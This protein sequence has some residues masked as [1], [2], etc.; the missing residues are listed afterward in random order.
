[1]LQ[2]IRDNSQSFVSKIIIGLII[3]VFAL[4][5]AESIVGGFFG[6]DRAV[7]VNGD[8][9][10]ETELA[11][12]IQNL[13]ANIGASAA[14]FDDEFIR[15][16]ALNQLIEDRLLMQA[17]ADAGLQISDDSIDRQIL[18][19]PQFQLGGVFDRDL[20]VRTMASQ[21]FT[22]AM[23]RQA[24]AERM[25]IGQLANAYAGTGFVTRQELDRIAALS[26]QRRDFR[27]VSVTVG[28][29][30]L[31]EAISDQ[32]I[33]AYYDNNSSRFMR[34]EQVVIDY[35]VLDRDQIFDEMEIDQADV[36][37]AYER[38]RDATVSRVERRASHI[39]F[40]LSGRTEAEALELAT[41]LKARID[42]GESFADLAATYSDDVISGRDGGDIGYSDGS[43]FPDAVE[44]ALRVLEEG[45]VSDPVRSEFGVHLVLLSESDVADFPDF[46][47]M[48]D[49]IERDLL[50]SQV[51][52]IYFARLE[53]LANL[54]FET[55][56][57]EAIE[58]ELGLPIQ[59]SEAFGRSGG[60]NRITGSSRVA[61]AA[62]SS[63]VLEDRLN[64]DVIEVE[65]GLS[66]VIHLR[67]HRPAEL[68]PLD[69]V[70]SE[71]ATLLRVE[72]ER[73][74]TRE[75]GEEIL[76]TLRD[77]GDVDALLETHELEWRQVEDV[78]REDPFVNPEIREAAFAVRLDADAPSSLG[79]QLSNGAYV[80]VELQSVTDGSVDDLSADEREMLAEIM[81]EGQA[82]RAFD[83][84]LENR[85][86]D[87]RIR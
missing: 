35:V 36:M 32:E 15:E 9:I 61:D 84:L 20:A 79:R 45:E 2:S 74:R 71:I 77:G 34:E 53:T 59:Q 44:E 39:L 41:E 50:S 8:E 29:R 23:Y 81:T 11:N 1:M 76:A 13:M 55:F 86:A 70:R 25:L 68:R 22:P 46:D 80:V 57:L 69:E 73:V 17:A 12:S 31:D 47:E 6:A 28:A 42:A 78:S 26:A 5:G 18:Q 48:A 64:S 37:A 43:V 19:T 4:F 30:T 33:R 66:V 63:D 87:A 83:A 49:R 65:E 72:R 27:Y 60:S 51:E 38:E 56:D 3:G 52:Q 58:D 14:D 7:R 16:V 82:R 67:E 54:A 10:T 85:R 24:L 21:G 75:I 40:E 62:F